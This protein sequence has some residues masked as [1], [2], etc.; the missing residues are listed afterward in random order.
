MVGILTWF[1]E[2]YA[3]WLVFKGLGVHIS[4]VEATFIY[5][6]ATLVGAL[7]MLPGGLVTTEG[8]MVGLLTILNLIRATSSA[9]TLLIRICTLWLAVMVGLIALY[10]Y[11]KN[12]SKEIEVS[13][14]S[15]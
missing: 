13:G 6:F 3:F 8:S 9:A 1:S 4:I 12:I 15:I 2:A 10:I 14:V 7:S 5:T 11:R